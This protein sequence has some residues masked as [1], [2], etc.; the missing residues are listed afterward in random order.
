MSIDSAE[1]GE[2][3]REKQRERED[4]EEAG[5]TQVYTTTI[6]VV[7]TLPRVTL[8]FE[9][10][11]NMEGDLFLG[12]TRQM[13]LY[14][15]N[16]GTVSVSDL[17]LEVKELYLENSTN[18]QDVYYAED[19]FHAHLLNGKDG[20]REK[21]K[22]VSWDLEGVLDSLPLQPR[23]TLCVPITVRAH[24]SC[25]GI[26]LSLRY[27]GDDAPPLSASSPSSSSLSPSPSPS[28]SP[29]AS[30]FHRC[31][32]HT[33]HWNVS[34]GVSLKSM[35][36]APLVSS[37][38]REAGSGQDDS[39]DECMLILE[40]QNSA[41]ASFRLFC[42][43]L[44]SSDPLSP[45]CPND[46]PHTDLPSPVASPSGEVSSFFGTEIISGVEEGKGN[47]DT[48]PTIDIGGSG[49]GRRERER[50]RDSH[51]KKGKGKKRSGVF[52]EKLCNK[53]V[54]LPIRKFSFGEQQDQVLRRLALGYNEIGIKGTDRRKM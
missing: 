26:E 25:C 40:V 17:T 33:I 29:T 30:P 2:R 22:Y 9:F 43:V 53:R 44:D 8:R 36:I 39:V 46:Q 19:K 42:N 15:Q 47:G 6:Q 41:D 37:S 49:V 24:P 23:A 54:I 14:V 32:V 16:I 20:K 48:K 1:E 35:D 18:A 12:E 50:E 45:A 4:E 13:S 21:H 27:A 52:I 34:A 28:L 5:V 51:R 11:G 3:E 7:P 31:T 38:Q 10:N